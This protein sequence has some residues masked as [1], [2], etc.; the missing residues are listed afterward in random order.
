MVNNRNHAMK[1]TS[2][3]LVIAGE[4]NPK[5]IFR[6][7]SH[8]LWIFLQVMGAKKRFERLSLAKV[9]AIWSILLVLDIQLP[10]KSQTNKHL[11]IF[12]NIL[13]I[14]ITRSVRRLE[15]MVNF[16]QNFEIPFDCSTKSLKF[17][18]FYIIFHVKKRNKDVECI[19]VVTSFLRIFII[20]L[21]VYI[22][23]SYSP[24]SFLEKISFRQNSK[25]HR[26]FLVFDGLRKY[27]RHQ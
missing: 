1:I 2:P 25:I 7:F 16:D 26:I 9:V 8:F 27:R 10:L 18:E 24:S 4:P 12:I 19:A 15:K 17:K 23:Y 21:I 22:C 3:K 14:K 6:K 20:Y 5:L 13:N 11:M